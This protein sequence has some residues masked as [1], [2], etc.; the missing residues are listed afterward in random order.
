MSKPSNQSNEM[1]E[2]AMQGDAEEATE[3]ER[4]KEPLISR[5]KLLATLGIGGIAA[6]SGGLWEVAGKSTAFASDQ[7]VTNSVYG[8]AIKNVKQSCLRS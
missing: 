6:V 2:A 1:E 7:T 5:R 8:L 3:R 4:H